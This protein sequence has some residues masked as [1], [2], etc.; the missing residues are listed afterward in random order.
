M[1]R[2]NPSRRRATAGSNAPFEGRVASRNCTRS[3]APN[4]LDRSS[5]TP[6][7][8]FPGIHHT[9][10]ARRL[11]T[12]DPG[13]ALLRTLF[14]ALHVCRCSGRGTV[15]SSRRPAGGWRRKRYAP[16][17]GQCHHMSARHLPKTARQPGRTI[18]SQW[19]Y[20]R[21]RFSMGVNPY[22]PMRCR[23]KAAKP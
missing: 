10:E 8:C 21:N 18:P 3:P 17:N 1:G 6:Y 4:D 23:F 15:A 2:T 19:A 22:I 20:H 13:H 7:H 5:I 16:G 14:A 11:Q 9:I 12:M